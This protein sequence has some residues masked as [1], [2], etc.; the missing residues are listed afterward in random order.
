M[1]L[2]SQVTEAHYLCYVRVLY[3]LSKY[4]EHM[5]RS[6]GLEIW[7]KMEIKIDETYH[8]SSFVALNMYTKFRE[9]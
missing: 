5:G 4:R 7:L 8:A 3:N 1:N 2:K 6:L 9:K